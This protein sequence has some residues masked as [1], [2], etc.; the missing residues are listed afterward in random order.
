M[1]VCMYVCT[2]TSYVDDPTCFYCNVTYFFSQAYTERQRK[3]KS[4]YATDILNLLRDRKRIHKFK[5]P[6]KEESLY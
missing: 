3:I 2:Y 1:Y 6:P 5:F 4:Q